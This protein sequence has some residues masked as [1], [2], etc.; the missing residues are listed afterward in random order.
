MILIVTGCWIHSENS[1][2][3]TEKTLTHYSMQISSRH[4]RPGMYAM[5]A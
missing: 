1:G 3:T 5:T 4:H 2:F